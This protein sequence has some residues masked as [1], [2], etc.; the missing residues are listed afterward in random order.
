[1]VVGPRSADMDS[2]RTCLVVSYF[3]CVSEGK[4][5][6]YD[7]TTFLKHSATTLTFSNQPH[8]SIPAL[9]SESRWPSTLFI[10][11]FGKNTQIQSGVYQDNEMRRRVS[12]LLARS[13][14]GHPTKD[15][16][17]EGRFKKH[18]TKLK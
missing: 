17:G 5:E 1:M 6:K 11:S 3:S 15:A 16:V 7:G 10:I 2:G 18:E 13:Y 14:V 9:Q 4:H 12:R 8:L